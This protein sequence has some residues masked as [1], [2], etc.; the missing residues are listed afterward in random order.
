MKAVAIFS[1]HGKIIFKKDP[2]NNECM[3]YFDLVRFKP[4]STHAIHIHEWGDTTNGCTSLGGHYNPTGQ[5]HGNLLSK[6]R[7]VGDLINNFTTDKYG[8]FSCCFID[9]HININ[10]IYG[11]SVVI[12]ELVDD[13]GLEGLYGTKYR[14]MPND[15]LM[16][17]C[18]EREYTGL[19]TKVSRILKLD[20][21]SKKTGNAGKRLDCAVI[22]R[23]AS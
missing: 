2:N 13:L 5:K 23:M 10:D 12:H 14:D 8:C 11:R 19:P 21:E 3:V 15:E 6:E 1:K 16:R 18:Q 22:G 17:L 7:H 4:F 20:Q 9:K